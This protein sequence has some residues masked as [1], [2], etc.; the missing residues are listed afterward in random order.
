MEATLGHSGGAFQSS[1]S[2]GA[3]A[4]PTPVTN[5]HTATTRHEAASRVF[6]R[7]L[8]GPIPR[9]DTRGERRRHQTMVKPAL[10]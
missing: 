5:K 7:S 4:R 2:E 6:K 1:L 8:T 10:R 3:E 9:L